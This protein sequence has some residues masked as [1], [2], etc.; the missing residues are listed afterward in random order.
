MS[1]ERFSAPSSSMMSPLAAEADEGLLAASAP[2]GIVLEMV[3]DI[4]LSCTC[5][6]TVSIL[7]LNLGLRPCRLAMHGDSPNFAILFAG[8]SHKP[9]SARE[10]EDS[11]KTSFLCQ[12]L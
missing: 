3:W 4:R 7:P 11:E 1:L 6:F 9:W 10:I 8:V 2:P 5:N 12:A